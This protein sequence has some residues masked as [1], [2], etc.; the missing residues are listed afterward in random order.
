MPSDPLASAWFKLDRGKEHLDRLNAA[1]QETVDEQPVKG[2][3]KDEYRGTT[4]SGKLVVDFT[5]LI[6]NAP[7]FTPDKHGVILGDC[8]GNFRAALDHAAW[9]LVRKRGTWPLAAKPARFVCFPMAKRRS[10]FWERS[11]QYLPGLSRKPYLTTLER[12]QPYRARRKAAPSVRCET[13]VTGTSIGSSSPSPSSQ[14]RVNIEFDR[15]ALVLLEHEWLFREGQQFK[16]GTRIL[17]QRLSVVR[18]SSK[19]M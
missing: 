1:I 11:S 3:L 17:R 19:C 9:T 7:V 14:Q 6:A 16:A 4:P 5:L 10:N 8:L 18:A 12:Y 2:D 13:S 15:K